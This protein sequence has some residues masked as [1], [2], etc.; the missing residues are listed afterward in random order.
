VGQDSVIRPTSAV[1]AIAKTRLG[2]TKPMIIR[3]PELWLV[4]G[5]A[6]TR[7]DL[8]GVAVAASVMPAIHLDHD[9]VDRTTSSWAARAEV[10]G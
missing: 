7:T 6:P 8:L 4:E 10:A 9:A 5:Q 1:T 3:A 2:R